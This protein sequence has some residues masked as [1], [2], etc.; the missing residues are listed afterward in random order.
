MLRVLLASGDVDLA[1]KAKEELGKICLVECCNDGDSALNLLRVFDPDV[2]MID[3]RLPGTDALAVIRTARA[4]FRKVGIL[5]VT[6]Q[7]DTY[8]E[9]HLAALHVDY[10]LIK[11]CKLSAVVSQILNIGSFVSDVC[12]SDAWG[13]NE[14]SS[15]LLDLGF[16]V[17]TGQYYA[18]KQAVLARFHSAQDT[19]MKD[20]YYQV[21]KAC[22]GN[23]LQKEKSIRDGIKV[24]AGRGDMRIWQLYFLPG[25]DGMWH[26]PT[27]E[28]FVTRIS[29]CL[30]Q[31]G[32]YKLPYETKKDWAM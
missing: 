28:E 11:P 2:M 19:L 22:G 5:V 24:A 10:V 23:S 25:H 31:S 8:T 18:V 9:Q 20:I 26:C 7:R 3:T 14:V 29:D 21:A 30:R 6:A 16:R 13:E 17:G 1:R 27:N 12:G 4:S 32:R 15:I